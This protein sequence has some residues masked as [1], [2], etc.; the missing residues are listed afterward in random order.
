MQSSRREL[1]VLCRS[2]QHRATQPAL[3][4]TRA[5][6]GPFPRTLLLLP[7]VQTLLGS[8][9]RRWTCHPTASTFVM[10]LFQRTLPTPL[11]PAVGPCVPPNILLH[12]P[13]RKYCPQLL[14][15]RHSIFDFPSRSW[16]DSFAHIRCQPLFP[17]PPMTAGL[18]PS[19][20]YMKTSL[21]G[22]KSLIRI[23]FDRLDAENQV[24]GTG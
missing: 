1:V 13:L 4:A 2:L 16:R 24:G 14:D 18:S 12:Q 22:S 20:T 21:D 5:A 15:R 23:E 17:Q 10:L 8:S 9:L 3:A 11:P 19:K 7:F 6:P